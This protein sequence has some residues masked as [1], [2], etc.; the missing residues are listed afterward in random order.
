[1]NNFDLG[2]ALL[3]ESEKTRIEFPD[4]I[5]SG[6]AGEYAGIIGQ[7]LESPPQFNFI[8]Y[9]TC[10]GNVIAD[11]VTLNSEIRPQPRFY[12]LLLG[13][14]ADTRKSTSINR[15]IEFFKETITDFNVCRG[16]G[17]AEGLQTRLEKSARLLLSFDEF[18]SFVSKCRLDGS[19]LLPCV[20]TLFENNFYESQIKNSSITLKH[21][22]LSIIAASTVETYETT[23]DRSFTDIGFSNRLFIVPGDGERKFAIPE[24]IPESEKR[25][26]GKKLSDVLSFAHTNKTLNIT[27]EA[28]AIFNNWYLNAEKSIHLKRLDTYALRFMPLIAINDLKPIIDNEIVEKIIKLMNWQLKVRKLYAPFDADNKIAQLEE[29]IRRNLSIKSLTERELKRAVHYNRCGVWCYDQAKKNLQ[30]SQEIVFSKK[31]QLW[32]ITESI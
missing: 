4:N 13:E 11:I 6:A 15:T 29:K 28:R 14:S 32:S 19:V 7:Y 18:K 10:L 24:I 22:Y 31:T 27:D 9:L 30:N 1:M 8:S 12:C 26:L 25:Y 23:W 3:K 16:V 21:V 5:L 17:S 2:E 20:T